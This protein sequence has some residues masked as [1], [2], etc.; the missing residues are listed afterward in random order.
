VEAWRL[1]GCAQEVEELAHAEDLHTLAGHLQQIQE[2]REELST[3]LNNRRSVAAA[4]GR[5]VGEVR[6]KSL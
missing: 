5:E 4:N 6:C 3:A 1:H 2:I